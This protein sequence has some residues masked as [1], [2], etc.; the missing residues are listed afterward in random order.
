MK[1][2]TAK[3]KGRETEQR[4]VQYLQEH[5]VPY[6]ERRRLTGSAD[7][8]DITGWP[9]VCVEVKSG[10][11]VDISRWLSELKA[12]KANANAK[13]GFVAVR[14]KG[15]PDPTDWYVVLPLSEMMTLVE[16]AGWTSKRES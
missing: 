9:G 2:A 10:A 12:E 14:P 6:A 15:L 1:P 5:G 13:L 16:D 11:R 4:L 3:S 8:G 7:R